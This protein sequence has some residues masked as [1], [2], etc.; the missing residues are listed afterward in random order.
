M[1]SF[2][3]DSRTVRVNADAASPALLG[4]LLN[5]CVEGMVLVD[6]DNPDTLIQAPQNIREAF[7]VTSEGP[8]FIVADPAKAKPRTVFTK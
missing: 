2:V 8:F 3:Y 7:A 6:P 4:A 5:C 1:A